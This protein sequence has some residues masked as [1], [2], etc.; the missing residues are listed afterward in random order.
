MVLMVMLMFVMMMVVMVMIM[1]V[2]RKGASALLRVHDDQTR[3]HYFN[4][5]VIAVFVTFVTFATDSDIY[6]V[7]MEYGRTSS[8]ADHLAEITPGKQG[9]GDMFLGTMLSAVKS[10]ATCMNQ[11]LTSRAEWI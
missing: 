4:F 3:P 8:G 2:R 5:P 1:L 9:C 7:N 11:L 10:F 6:S